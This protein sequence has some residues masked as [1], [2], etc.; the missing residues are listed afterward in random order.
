MLFVIVSVLFI[1]ST[2]SWALMASGDSGYLTAIFFSAFSNVRRAQ[3][4]CWRSFQLFAW[5]LPKPP[6]ETSHGG[7][8]AAAAEFERQILLAACRF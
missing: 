7:G 6:P 5:P 4:R 2:I 8:A 3:L 1:S